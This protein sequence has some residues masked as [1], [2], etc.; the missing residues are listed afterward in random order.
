MQEC[1]ASAQ[2]WLTSISAEMISKQ[3]GGFELR[4]VVKPLVFFCRHLALVALCHVFSRH[5]T[6][7][8][9]ILYT[10][11]VVAFGLALLI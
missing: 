11:T 4:G 6:S 2:R 9:D 8:S 10:Y 1:W 5:A 7:N 3:A